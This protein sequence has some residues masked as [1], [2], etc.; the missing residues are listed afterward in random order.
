MHAIIHKDSKYY[1]SAVFGCYTE[2]DDNG[3]DRD[4]WIVWDQEKEK[5]I[6]WYTFRPDSVYYQQQILIVDSDQS[7]WIL[8]KDGEGCVN[9]LNRNLI[10][11]IVNT[12]EQPKNILEQC[13]A[14][15]KN[16]VYQDVR[17]VTN[18][19]DIKDLNWI[20][21]YFHD[22][23]IT[24]QELQ[25]D[26]KLFLRFDGIWGCNIEVWFWDDLLYNTSLNDTDFE[27]YYWYGSTLLIQGGF[28][29]LVDEEDAK[30]EQITSYYCYFKARH[31]KYRI[32][33]KLN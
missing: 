20:A 5:L 25:N 28:V 8:N 2:H 32:I 10:H 1:V 30:M 13:K 23:H 4:Y 7:N 15:D 33:P 16:Y 12:K 26:G 6:K 27:D 11:S 21:V 31:M 14:M 22:A 18:K 29:Y 9:F 3:D 24:K 19:K 17:K